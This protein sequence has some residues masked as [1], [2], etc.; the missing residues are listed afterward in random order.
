MYLNTLIND[1]P[2]YENAALSALG[3]TKQGIVILHH[4]ILAFQN[5]PL[6]IN[7][8]EFNPQKY[9]NYYLDVLMAFHV[10]ASPILF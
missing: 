6:W 9:H 5:W 10:T 8:A 4:S 7:L 1:D 3:E 2:W